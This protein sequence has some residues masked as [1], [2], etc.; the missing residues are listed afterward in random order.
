MM[1]IGSQTRLTSEIPEYAPES[2]FRAAVR[3]KEELKDL[4]KVY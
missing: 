2:K 4:K 3:I 1:E